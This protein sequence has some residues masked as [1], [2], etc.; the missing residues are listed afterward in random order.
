MRVAPAPSATGTVRVVGVEERSVLSWIRDVVGE[1]C[2]PLKGIKGFEVTPQGRVF[3]RAV[4]HGLLLALSNLDYHDAAFLPPRVGEVDVTDAASLAKA[5]RELE[6]QMKA[7][8]KRLEFEEAGQ[9]R[10]RIKELR[11]QQIYKT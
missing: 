6:K 5:I 4:E 2:Q 10:D 11:D 1:T 9:L 8:A 3:A 7:A